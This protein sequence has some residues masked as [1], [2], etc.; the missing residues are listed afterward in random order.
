MFLPPARAPVLLGSSEMIYF[1]ESRLYC[2]K[3]NDFL[4]IWTHWQFPAKGRLMALM[5]KNASHGD[6]RNGHL[7]DVGGLS[8][9]VRIRAHLADSSMRVKITIH[10]FHSWNMQILHFQTSAF[11]IKSVFWKNKTDVYITRRSVQST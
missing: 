8:R 1:P 11:P 3:A 5:E 10:D 6:P 2:F 7:P 9:R 4:S